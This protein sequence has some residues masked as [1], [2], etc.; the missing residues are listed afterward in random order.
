MF[1]YYNLIMK[2]QSMVAIIVLPQCNYAT[3]DMLV[4]LLRSELLK[5]LIC[6]VSI[7]IIFMQTSF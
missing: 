5:T 6:G 4:E 2:K 3:I 1:S 7:M